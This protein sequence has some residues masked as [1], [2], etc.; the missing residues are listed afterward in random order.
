MSYSAV[1]PVSRHDMMAIMAV[2]GTSQ[3]S[4]MTCGT[5][6]YDKRLPKTMVQTVTHEAR[7]SGQGDLRDLT[8]VVAAAVSGSGLSAGIVTV[9]VVGS[10]AGITTIEFE[11]GAVADF[12]AALERLAPRNGPYRHHERWGDDNGSSHVRAALL[13]PS[14][15]LPFTD[16]RVQLGTW[17]QIVLAE[18]DTRPR[19]RR[20]VVQ[21]LG[22]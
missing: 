19:D 14:L 7:T 15:T 4:V 11:P 18:L 20:V 17:Q 13:G 22:E 12:G 9:A 6:C 5:T 3:L 10:T 2:R 8:E 1:V 16:G 21:I